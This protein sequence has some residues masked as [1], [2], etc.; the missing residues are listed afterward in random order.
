MTKIY[1]FLKLPIS[2]SQDLSVAALDYTTTLTR[3]FRVKSIS[4]KFS[5]AITETITITRDSKVGANYDAVLR[6]KDLVAET[7]YVY[8]P[9]RGDD[10]YNAGDKIR[11]QC[12][13]ANSVGIV[14]VEL[15]LVEG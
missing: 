9:E 11:I 15:K 4:F 2:T 3:K 14:Y 13:D 10:A 5:Q 7:T 12:T 8:V 6:N 1:D